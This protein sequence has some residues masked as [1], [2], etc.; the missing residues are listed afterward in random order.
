[1][2][3]ALTTVLVLAPGTPARAEMR[4]AVSFFYDELEPYGAWVHHPRYGWVWYPR[5]RPVGWS[6]YTYG[7]WVWTAEYGWYWDSEE[8]WGWATYHYGRWA[9]TDAYGWVWVPDDEWGPAW[10]EWR[11][12]GGYVGWCAMPPEVAWRS[13]TFVYAQV[14]MTS[15]R[16]RP[17]WVFVAEASF[18]EPDPWR[19][20]AP[21][22]RNRA[23]LKAS[24]RTTNYSAVNARI[25]NRSVDVRKISA[26]ANVHIRP[27]EVVTYDT[28]VR[29]R[30]KAN[31]SGRIAVYRPR[32]GVRAKARVHTPPVSAR[33]KGRS[34]RDLPPPIDGHTRG[35]LDT[36]RSIDAG[37][38]ASI[39]IGGG[40]IGIGGGG[41]ISIGR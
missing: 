37:G 4:V 21:P 23:M 32:I 18:T 19:Y 31:R 3:V 27:V 24:V 34:E 41:G 22:K 14:D 10:V 6:P 35:S 25:V 39:G 33:I 13:G 20:R 16:Y 15:P 9:Y 17:C 5:H 36:G 8:E 26:A 1:M 11:T 7:R 40:G 12:G 2:L 38:G 29:A 30:A 28:D